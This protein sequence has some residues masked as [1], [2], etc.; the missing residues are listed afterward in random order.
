MAEE[1]SDTSHRWTA[2]RW[3]ALVPSIVKGETS[4]QA[5]ARKHG[6][7]VAEIPDAERPAGVIVHWPSVRRVRS[8]NSS[9]GGR[10]GSSHWWR[11]FG[12]SS[13]SSTQSRADA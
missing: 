2:K 9:T 3:A 4:A 12:R 1:S 6:L 11:N 7:T 8:G 13:R 5:G 10:R